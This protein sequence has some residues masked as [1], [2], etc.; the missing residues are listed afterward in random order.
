M[1]TLKPRTAS[2]ELDESIKIAI[3]SLSA[4][5]PDSD[6]YAKIVTQIERQ[7]VLRTAQ[8]ASRWHISPDTA[9]IVIGNLLGI[10]LIVGFERAHV[11]TSAAKNFV[12]KASH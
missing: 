6:E 5:P 9:A 4:Y 3:D 1:F 10:A 8:K 2:S 12:M 7:C 11:M